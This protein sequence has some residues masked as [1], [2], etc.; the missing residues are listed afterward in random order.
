MSVLTAKVAGV[1][2]VDRLR[3]RPSRASR[4]PAIVA[5]MHAR[6][7]RRDLRPRRRAGRRR[8]GDRHRDDRA[9]RH[10][11]RPR[12]RLSSPR[13][14]ASS[15]AASASTSSPARPR[16]WSSPTRRSTPRC[17]PPTCSARPSTARLARDPAHQLARR[18][19]R[20]RWPRS[21]ASS[22]SCPPP[23]SRARRGATT[24]RSSSATRYDEMLTRGRP[25][26]LRARAGDDRDRDYFPRAT[27]T[28]YGALFLGPRDQ[29]RLW[30]QGDRHQPHAA[31]A[32]G[33]RATPAAC[34]S[35]SSSRPA[36]TRSVTTDEA[37][38]MI[39]EY[40]SRLCVIE[41]FC[42]PRRA[43]QPAA[44][45]ATAAATSPSAPR[46]A[47]G[48]PPNDS[49]TCRAPPA[50]RLDG[51]HALVTGGTRGI[52]LGCGGRAGRSRR[53]G[54]HRRPRAGEVDAAVGRHARAR[55]ARPTACRSTSPTSPPS[56]P[57]SPRAARFDIL[58]NSA[59][60]ARHAPASETSPRPTTTPS[61]T[62]TSRGASS[63]PR[64]SPRGWSRP[65]SP[66]RSSH[67][68]A[69]GPCRRTATARVYCASKFAV[70]GL[71]KA[72][73]IELAPHSIR[74][75]TICP[76]FIDTELTASDLR[77]P[78]RSAA[79]RRGKIKLGR[80]GRVEDIM[81]AVVFLASDASA[82]MTGSSLMV[83]GG[84]TAE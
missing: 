21:S 41:G 14:S 10:A 25:H 8:D 5:A 78:R 68:L 23:T 2:R 42:R 64:P 43:G 57:S 73:A 37:S 20:R 35:A 18:S 50:F 17:A 28:N 63:S 24:A 84:W 52:G 79:W 36:P 29:R 44:C 49:W 62:S 40:C 6:R 38:A 67:L 30:R 13:P 19:P 3:R 9:G 7:R 56:A 83:D 53:A 82:L 70:E 72:M 11:G 48:R 66:A 60:T 15:T 39:G 54:D 12:Q 69:D 46:P 22:R 16:R 47:S 26:R 75:N 61:S 59:G 34:G 45:A 58:V 1:Q 80:L 33:R 27:C 65:A 55:A 81:G 74:V 76:T 4:T 32:E 31:D 51:Q 71:T 77:R